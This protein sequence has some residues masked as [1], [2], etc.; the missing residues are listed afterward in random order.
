MRASLAY[1]TGSGDASAALL[2]AWTHW[3]NASHSRHLALS[4]D[5]SR[6]DGHADHDDGGTCGGTC[7]GEGSTAAA[8]LD[9]DLAL[10]M[11]NTMASIQVRSSSMREYIYM[12]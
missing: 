8:P 10:V 11:R 1:F 9:L 2:M 12:Y 7:P 3:L 5:N 4:G 6:Q